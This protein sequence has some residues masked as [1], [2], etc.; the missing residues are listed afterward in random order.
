ME[1]Y[2]ES[3]KD[4]M[5][6]AI[7]T[8]LRELSTI[9]TGRASP[10]LLDMVRVQVQ[11]YGATMPI[12]QL[13]TVTAPDPRLLVVNPW[14]KTTLG[15]IER[16]ITASGLGLNPGNDG[17][18]IRV[19]IPALTG[20]RRQDLVKQVGRMTEDAKVR[21][22][23]VRKEYNDLFKDLQ[24]S[25]EITEDE[26]RRALDAVQKSTDGHAA[27]VDEISLGKQKEVMEV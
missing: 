24:D 12:N 13:A 20:E 15:D 22:R 8:F 23:R 14:D 3:L 6:K 2:L 16:A 27:R 7:E 9:R 19:P 18:L 5:A 21:V 4:D 10:Q 17:S 26:L 25:S 1:E 11:S